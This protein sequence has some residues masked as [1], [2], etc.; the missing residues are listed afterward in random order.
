MFKFAVMNNT[1][2]KKTKKKHDCKIR[3]RLM[4]LIKLLYKVAKNIFLKA[5]ASH[6]LVSGFTPCPTGGTPDLSWLVKNYFIV[7]Y[8]QL[9]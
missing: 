7:I 4:G 9:F 8:S 2:C 5:V 6:P 1:I 3:K